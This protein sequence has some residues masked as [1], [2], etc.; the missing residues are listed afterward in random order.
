MGRIATTQKF[1]SKT[2]VTVQDSDQLSRYFSEIR[3]FESLTKEQENEL[4]IR[5]QKHNDPVALNNLI[6]A[7]LKFVVSVAKK[8][9][10]QGALLM[11][12]IS[13]GN[14]GMIEA[15]HRFDVKED[16]K[17]FSYAVWW[18]RMKIFT[19]INLHKRT[20]RLPD[21]RWLLVD[22]IKKD[23]AKLEQKL[24]R[25]PSIEELCEYLKDEYKPDEIKEAILHADRLASLQDRTGP[26]EEDLTLG[27]TIED[28]SN[29]IDSTNHQES[30]VEDL[31]RFLFH[32]SQQEYDVLCLSIGLN[33]EPTIRNQDIAKLLKMKQKDVVKFKS[34]AIK[35]LKKLKNIGVLKDYLA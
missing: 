16:I 21:N 11:D 33:K 5:V 19:S 18:I 15:A 31:G 1:E 30:I 2:Q 9:Q 24:D 35:R 28:K 12:L 29:Q 4:I 34:K 27:D 20:I 17:F 6:K 13:E 23:I 7:N 22:K 3:N 14:A 26:N 10:G 8:Y 25:Y 32:I